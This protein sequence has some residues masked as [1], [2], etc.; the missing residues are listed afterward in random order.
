MFIVVTLQESWVYLMCRMVHSFTCAGIL[1]SQYI[2]MSQFSGMGTVGNAYIRAGWCE[3]SKLCKNINV[4][5][6]SICSW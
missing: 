2:N 1:P 3:V 4:C 6:I 5:C